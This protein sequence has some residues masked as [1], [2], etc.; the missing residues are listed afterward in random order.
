MPL[1]CSACKVFISTA[2]RNAAQACTSEV[3]RKLLRCAEA[4]ANR[5]Y[6]GRPVD[7]LGQWHQGVAMQRACRWEPWCGTTAQAT[8]TA[9]AE[10]TGQP[11]KQLHRIHERYRVGLPGSREKT[12]AAQ[13][14][15]QGKQRRIYREQGQ[16]CTAWPTASHGH[17]CRCRPQ[18]Q[19][20]ST[21]LSSSIRGSTSTS[22]R[23]SGR[24]HYHGSQCCTTWTK[25]SVA[26]LVHESPDHRVP[27][28]LLL[29]HD[30]ETTPGSVG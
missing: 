14:A 21:W 10:C 23:R 11:E 1:I 13:P 25:Q 17:H 29:A 6:Q 4:F 20:C 28:T 24:H 19:C 27:T 18:Y 8:E 15:R 7:S 5:D 12:R 3:G 22:T 16:C 2:M 26:A 9:A 30:Y